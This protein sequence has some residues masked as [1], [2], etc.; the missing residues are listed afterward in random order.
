MALGHELALALFWMILLKGIT[1]ISGKYGIHNDF[2][3]IIWNQSFKLES[4]FANERW[5]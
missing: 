3:I 5:I 1:G 4:N 2:I